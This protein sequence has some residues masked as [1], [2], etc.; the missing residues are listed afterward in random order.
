MKC[1]VTDKG[2]AEIRAFL[3]ANHR[4]CIH[5]KDHFTDAML[6]E[7]AKMAEEAAE[8]DNAPVVTIQAYNSVNN[9][10]QHYLLREDSIVCK[11]EFQLNDFW[12]GVN[13]K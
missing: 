4:E 8:R 12:T 3:Q 5:N 11:T 7:W 1:K 2:L 13:R 6:L 10:V 9:R